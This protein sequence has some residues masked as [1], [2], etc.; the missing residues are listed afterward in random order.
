MP[1]VL[2]NYPFEKLLISCV[3]G[4]V[5]I[6]PSRN[7]NYPIYVSQVLR[8][9]VCC[10]HMEVICNTIGYWFLYDSHALYFEVSNN[11]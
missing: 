11:N 9:S 8:A 4:Q 10:G 2:R 3:G 7:T 6:S 5:N 1:S